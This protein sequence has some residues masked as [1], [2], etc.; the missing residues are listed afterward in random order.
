MTMRRAQEA[1]RCQRNSRAPDVHAQSNYK[2]NM[3]NLHTEQ[4]EI[5]MTNV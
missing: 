4:I 3:N 5:A 2:Y 1:S